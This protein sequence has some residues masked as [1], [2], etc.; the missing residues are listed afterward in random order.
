ILEA[1][2]QLGMQVM[3]EG[4]STF[5]HN[6][7]M[8]V[9][10]HT[11]VEHN[12]PPETLYDDVLQLWKGSGTANTPTL[13][14]SYGG[15]TGENYWYQH[16]DVWKHPRLMTFV[17]RY[18][19]EPRSRRRQKAP[20][21]DYNHIRISQ[22]LKKLVDQGQLVNVGAHGQLAG[23]ALH[24][25]M[26]MFEQGGMSPYEALRAA[27][28]SPAQTMGMDGEL[29]SIEAGKLADLVVMDKNPLE[30]IR[31]S[32]SVS[33]VMLNGRLF[34]AASM[35]QIGPERDRVGSKAFGEG[36][37]ALGIGK[38]WSQNSDGQGLAHTT[39]SCGSVH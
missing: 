22:N 27:T 16:T 19:V 35:D 33:M 3:P 20:E 11:T 39:C 13:V 1:A 29:G 31:N 23:L 15:L 14:V 25:E 2:R 24:W 6:M 18:V 4:G 7:N 32:D 5:M 30:N 26:W 17:P 28:L 12:M 36:A 21:G 34:D 37:G 9:D 10:G 8:I 38:W